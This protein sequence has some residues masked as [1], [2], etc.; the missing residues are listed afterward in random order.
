L[1]WQAKLVLN[2][3]FGPNSGRVPI[4]ASGAWPTSGPPP[5]WA[6]LT[7]TGPFPGETRR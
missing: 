3:G 4:G 2:E 5:D 1:F 7:V 6:P